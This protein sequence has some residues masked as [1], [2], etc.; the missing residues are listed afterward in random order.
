MPADPPVL[1]PVLVSKL[2]EVVDPAVAAAAVEEAAAAVFAA[3]VAAAAV[4]EITLATELIAAAIDCTV[5]CLEYSITVVEPAGTFV[6]VV[7]AVV[8]VV[9]VSVVVVAVYAV[10]VRANVAWLPVAI[11]APVDVVAVMVIV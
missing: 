4:V 11:A 1:P 6:V 5:I 8:V 9:V 7:A 2:F 10:S 3:A